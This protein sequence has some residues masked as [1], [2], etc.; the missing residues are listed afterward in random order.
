MAD[1]AIGMI[2][3]KGY[4]A[5]LSAA[6][7]MVKAANVA[8]VGRQEV[9]DGL[10]SVTIV[11]DVGAVKAATE[12]GAETAS[13]VG[14]AD[15]GAR[16]PVAARGTRQALHH[17]RRVAGPGATVPLTAL[18]VP[19]AAGSPPGP[20][21]AAAVRRLPGDAGP[22]PRLPADGRRA[23]ADRR[24]GPGP[25][26]RAGHRSRAARGAYGRAGH[27]VRRTAVRRAGGARAGPGRGAAGRAGHPGRAAGQRGRPAPAAG[28]VLRRDR[29]HHRPAG[30][31]HQPDQGRLHDPSR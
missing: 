4:V 6:D 19:R 26:H 13:S 31:P 11:G 1:N 23:R 8:I 7:A 21:P 16:N 17:P 30:H 15:L 10:V 25:G 29:G 20:G 22:G 12:A 2:E 3:T 5:A 27:P 24:G 9:G 28:A 18:P 14:R